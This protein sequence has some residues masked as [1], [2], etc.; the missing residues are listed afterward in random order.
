MSTIN[1]STTIPPMTLPAA[2]S[3]AAP[4]AAAT[5]PAASGSVASS[6]VA[7][8]PSVASQ[9]ATNPVTTSASAAANA[10]NTPASTAAT[11]APAVE[12]SK[13]VVRTG[14][15][16]DTRP[17]RDTYVD[18]INTKHISQQ[19]ADN[20]FQ[21]INPN[22][23]E[24]LLTRSVERLTTEINKNQ[25]QISNTVNA[26]SMIQVANDSLDEIQ[27][28]LKE[29]Q[30]LAQGTP[31]E[32]K[33]G[34]SQEEFQTQVEDTQAQ[35]LDIV[36]G[37]QDLFDST[38]YGGDPLLTQNTNQT[39]ASH[40]ETQYGVTVVTHNVDGKFEREGLYQIDLNSPE[41]IRDSLSAING[42]MDV[43]RDIRSQYNAQETDFNT[44]MK[45][46]FS[47]QEQL[48]AM[49]DRITSTD[50]AIQVAE[51]AQQ[52][53]INDARGSVLAQANADSNKALNLLTT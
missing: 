12:T 49:H 35:A 27:G 10:V 6:Q 4:V 2:S 8:S 22:Q 21:Q 52:N 28:G 11:A 20:T 34:Q 16:Q 32:R 26:Y 46:L 17:A 50:F 39:F 37:I 51:R 40:N 48:D 24:A 7:S 47:T 3:N 44:T 9:A 15:G 5:T 19:Q 45:K 18:K 25:K 41:S 1:G 33:E 53:M 38:K 14:S 42:S 43:V 29:L 23:K 13:E 30:K 36:A 31:N